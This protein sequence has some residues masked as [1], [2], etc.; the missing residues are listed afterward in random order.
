[1]IRKL[2]E[3]CKQKSNPNKNKQYGGGPIAT[4]ISVS[5]F[6][7]KFKTFLNVCVMHG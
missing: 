6:P 3:K 1:L 2:N 7:P 5:K 4:D